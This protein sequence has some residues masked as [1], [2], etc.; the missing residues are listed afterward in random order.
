MQDY[1]A[2]E[3]IDILIECGYED[4]PEFWGEA[5]DPMP[6]VEAG[7]TWIFDGRSLVHVLGPVDDRGIWAVAGDASLFPVGMVFTEVARP[8]WQLLEAA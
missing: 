3:I 2:K 6:E 4:T 8:Q 5:G 1:D 7:Q